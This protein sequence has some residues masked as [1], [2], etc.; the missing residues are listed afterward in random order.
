M[1]TSVSKKRAQ[2]HL[3][4][5][6]NPQKNSIKYRKRIQDEKENIKYARECLRGFENERSEKS[7]R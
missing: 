3:Q 6:R 2:E 4:E 5:V 7:A 1:T